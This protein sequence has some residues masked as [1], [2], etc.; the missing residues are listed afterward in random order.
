MKRGLKCGIS[1]GVFVY[2][3]LRDSFLRLLGMS[4]KGTCVILYYHSVPSSQRERFARQLDVILRYAKPVAVG[5]RLTFA[6]RMHYAGITFDDGFENFAEVAL[7]ELA[8]RKIPSTM[9]VIADATGKA[10]GPY[11]RPEKVMSVEQLRALPQDLVTIGSHTLTHP[12]L[13]GLPEQE[14]AHEI[15]RSREQIQ[16][17]LNRSVLLFSF[18]FG[19]FSEKLIDYCRQAGYQRVFTTLPRLAFEDSGEFAVGRV[20]VDPD[21]SPLEFRLKI[22]GAYRWLPWAFALKRKLMPLSS[23]P[24]A[25]TND[26]RS[27]LLASGHSVIQDPIG[28]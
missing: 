25:R 17:M 3:V 20:R 23:S 24:V 19:G 13:P 21:D 9:F 1:L 27:D 5:E 12:Y 16:L 7:P 28:Q 15:G 22:A 4:T 8:K 6:P 10:F 14:A 2:T 18:P 26:A 11:G